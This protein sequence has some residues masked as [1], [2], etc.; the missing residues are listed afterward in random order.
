MMLMD[1]LFDMFLQAQSQSISETTFGRMS[2]LIG[3][4]TIFPK[5]AEPRESLQRQTSSADV[6]SRGSEASSN[7]PPL[8]KNAS[9][10][11]DISDVSSQCSAHSVSARRTSSWCFDEKVLIQ[12]LYKVIIHPD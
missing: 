11:S 10:S 9:M 1:M 6:R 2:D 5:S 7:A 3:S 4:F 12:S 8:R